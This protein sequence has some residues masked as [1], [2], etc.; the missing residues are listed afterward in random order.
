M[1][2]TALETWNLGKVLRGRTVL[3][4]ISLEVPQGGVFALLGPAGSGINTF[5]K[6]ILGVQAPTSG[7]GL[8]LGLDILTRGL[9]IREKVGFTG[10]ATR[11]YGYMSVARM[12]KFCRG[13]YPQWDD[14][15]AAKIL[16]QF[17]LP[18]AVKI[19]E[20]SPEEQQGL[21]LALALAPKPDLLLLDRPTEGF[22][23][24]R[25]RL[26]FDLA[27]SEMDSRG[28]TIIISS[29]TLDEVSSVADHAALL[30]R[31]RLLHTGPMAELRPAAR[32]IRV[33]FQKEPQELPFHHPGIS[34]VRREKNA[35]IVTVTENLEE[36]WQKI[37]AVP[38]FALELDDSGLEGLISRYAKEERKSGTVLPLR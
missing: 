35:Y 10:Q 23:P 18:L 25:R 6:I 14:A 7:G 33:V 2:M 26:Y 8:C 34:R 27:R 24:V 32:E 20:L 9:Q 19:H 1:T 13:F 37:A 29:S 36:V 5:L 15:L 28:G 30:H 31:G 22:D 16:M 4:D 17:E 12:L 38:H 11:Y 3:E 21:G